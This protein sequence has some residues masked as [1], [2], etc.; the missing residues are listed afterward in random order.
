MNEPQDVGVLLH[1]LH[2]A[3]IEHILIGGLAVRAH[4]FAVVGSITRVRSFG[5]DNT[6]D[7]IP[8]FRRSEAHNGPEEGV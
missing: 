3:G 1:R 7:N 6:R 4:P 5:R 8:E 2:E